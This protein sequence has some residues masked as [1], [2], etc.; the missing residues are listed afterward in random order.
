M[1]VLSGVAQGEKERKE[2]VGI[3]GKWVD[4]RSFLNSFHDFE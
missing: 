4:E 2:W 1:R 3:L